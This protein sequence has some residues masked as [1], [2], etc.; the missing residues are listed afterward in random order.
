MIK[1][2]LDLN[3][4]L[5]PPTRK[6]QE[7]KIMSMLNSTISVDASVNATLIEDDPLNRYIDIEIID[8]E[9]DY[10]T[11]LVLGVAIGQTMLL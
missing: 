8:E 11:V 6:V 2:K 9:A 4:N 3:L 7:E 1:L 10:N 5:F